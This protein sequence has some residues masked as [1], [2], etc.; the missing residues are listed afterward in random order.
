MARGYCTRCGEML[1][2]NVDALCMDCFISDDIASTEARLEREL[3]A[4]KKKEKQPESVEPDRCESCQRIV[5]PG[6]YRCEPCK[7]EDREFGEV[8]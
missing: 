6:A 1:S 3:E 8:Y 5:N 2:Q 7:F 4:K